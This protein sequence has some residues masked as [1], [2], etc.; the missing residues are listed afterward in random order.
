MTRTG[1][2][3]HVEIVPDDHAVQ[4]DPDERQRR[5]RA[6]MA[7]Q[8][9]LHMFRPQ[10]LSQERVVP[11]IDHSDGEIVARSPIAVGQLQLFVRQRFR[12]GTL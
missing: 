1:H 9:V 10:R 7:E 11:E 2:E 4:M 5:A 6:P 12:L 8:P 3:D